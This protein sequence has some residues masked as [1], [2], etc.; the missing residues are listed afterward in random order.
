M[1]L[2]DLL[3]LAGIVNPEVLN[4]IQPTAP[5]A[6]CGCSM[7]EAEGAGFDTATT[8]PEPEVLE[9]PMA[10]MGSDAD[11]SLRRYLKA[12]GDHVT[13]DENVYADYTVEDV[14]E[15]YAAFKEG[16]SAK[17]DYLDFD[18]DGNKKEPMK[19][20]LKDKEEVDEAADDATDVVEMNTNEANN[21]LAYLKKLAG[22]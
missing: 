13:V 7:E 17:P 8:E 10:A 6:D 15:A 2:R 19:K 9:D 22:L 18:G 1:D 14:T 4:R 20:A 3:T 16:K 21:E 12:K 11:L 5:E